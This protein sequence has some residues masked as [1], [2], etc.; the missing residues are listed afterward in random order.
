MAVR[1]VYCFFVP[2]GYMT[3]S[4]KAGSDALIECRT[5]NIREKIPMRKRSENKTMRRF[6]AGAKFLKKKEE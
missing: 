3:T 4:K 1:L 2:D 6:G 5:D